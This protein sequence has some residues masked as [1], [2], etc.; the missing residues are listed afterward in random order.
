MTS[1]IFAAFADPADA[2]KAAGALLDHGLHEDEVSF[3]ANES[4]NKVRCV[5]PSVVI[6]RDN[7]S[8]SAHTQREVENNE[9]IGSSYGHAVINETGR[10][11]SQPGEWGVPGSNMAYGAEM[12]GG[13]ESS[14]PITH[15][16]AGHEAIGNDDGGPTVHP[17][18]YD[19]NQ[20]VNVQE[21]PQI[22]DTIVERPEIGAKKGITTT[23]P[24]DAGAGA[25][26]G[27]AAGVGIGALAVLA[28]LFI[29]GVGLVLGGGALAT[30]LAG[31]AGAVGA[32]AIA[33]GVVGYLKDQGV[34]EEAI[35]VYREAFDRGGAI[36]AVAVPPEFVR[37]DIEA[38]LA[39]YGA[40]NIEM[41][42]QVRTA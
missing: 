32:G 37:A 15:Y 39:K 16:P 8:Q 1:T 7:E 33:G 11:I 30:A 17:E 25:A 42:G 34:P 18:G 27:V 28:S 6:P 2:E 14:D 23:T 12:A 13:I 36:L 41:Y 5:Q 35:T 21:P 3:V 31:L 40:A 20:P 22:C 4:Y 29:P 38:I 24:E 10:P 26:T 9:V 19:P